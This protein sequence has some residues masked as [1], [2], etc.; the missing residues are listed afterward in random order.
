[1]PKFQVSA[2]LNHSA[3]LL[4]KFEDDMMMKKAEGPQL[5]QK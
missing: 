2:I 5:M 4:M 3:T 1:M